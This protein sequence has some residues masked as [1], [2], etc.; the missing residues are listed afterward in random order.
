LHFILSEGSIEK[1]VNVVSAKSWLW[2]FGS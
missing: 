2:N 1:E